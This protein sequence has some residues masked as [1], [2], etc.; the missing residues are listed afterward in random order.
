MSKYTELL[1]EYQVHIYSMH[2][3]THVHTHTL[4]FTVHIIVVIVILKQKLL[5]S[6]FPSHFFFWLNESIG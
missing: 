3:V 4:D 6:F 5:Q 1:Q 2:S